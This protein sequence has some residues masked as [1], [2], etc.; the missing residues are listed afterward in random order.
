MPTYL[1]FILILLKL[2]ISIEFL[3]DT[4]NAPLH[5]V[6]MKELTL[7]VQTDFLAE[8][9]KNI[10]NHMCYQRYSHGESYFK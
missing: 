2:N 7:E 5:L 10:C 4:S 6:D 1:L 3:I 8:A 9:L